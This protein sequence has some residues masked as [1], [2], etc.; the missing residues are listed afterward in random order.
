MRDKSVTRLAAFALRNGARASDSE[1]GWQLQIIHRPK[2]VVMYDYLASAIADRMPRT[3]RMTPTS[4][5]T[6][7]Q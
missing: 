6:S 1:L 7:L 5:P 3:T 2:W 4:T